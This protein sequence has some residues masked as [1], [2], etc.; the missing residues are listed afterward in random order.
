MSP[1]LFA[2]L[3]AP[4]LLAACGSEPAPQVASECNS[5]AY[6]EIG[7]P[8]DLVDETGQPVTEGDFKGEPSLVY[9]GFTYCPD[10][11]PL[12]LVRLANAINTLPEDITPPRTIMISVDPERDTPEQ[13]AT[14]ITSSAFPENMTGLTG[15]D[16]Q[17]K[18]AA[19][20]FMSG[21]Q[22]V[23]DPGSAMGYTMDHMDLVYLMDETWTLATF[24]SSS[25]TPAEIGACLAQKL[26]G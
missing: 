20:A 6:A 2:L 3:A 9:F 19:E 22:K 24:F 21:Y 13:L 5:R 23:E 12:T 17:I 25:S 8:I 4:L 14:Y 15:S 7:G 18:A 11:C 16:A 10:V 26:K 1:R